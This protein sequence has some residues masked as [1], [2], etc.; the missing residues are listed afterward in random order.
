MKTSSKPPSRRRA[1]S[2]SFPHH[3]FPC[4]APSP[5]RFIMV[6]KLRNSARPNAAELRRRRDRASPPLPSPLPKRSRTAPA[7]LCEALCQRCAIYLL[8]RDDKDACDMKDDQRCRRC[9]RSRKECKTV[10]AC[11]APALTRL[12]TFPRS[13]RSLSRS[14]TRSST[15]GTAAPTTTRT[16]RRRFA[17]A[18]PARTRRCASTSATSIAALASRS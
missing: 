7:K 15:I 12:L 2:S 13:R 14:S 16:G 9:A 4:A 10:S 11:A 18:S 17:S 1:S 3:H 5:R 8:S 6:P